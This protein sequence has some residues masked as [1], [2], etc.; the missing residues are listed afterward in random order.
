[1]K[2]L[3][4]ILFIVLLIACDSSD[5]E[6]E[7]NEPEV[8][9]PSNLLYPNSQYTFVTGTTGTTGTP[10]ITNGGDPNLRFSITAPSNPNLSIDSI[11]GVI[12]VSSSLSLGNYNIDV[13]VR[14][15]AGVTSFENI[16]KI[17]IVAA[18]TAP[19]SLSWTVDSLVVPKTQ[20]R[21]STA[22]SINTGGSPITS[23][24]LINSPAGFS[25]SNS[26][27]ITAASTLSKGVYMLSVR[28]TNSVG[29]TDFNNVFR[30]RVRTVTYTLDM[31]TFFTDN[32][33]PCHA[34]GGG[35]PNWLNYTNAR[36][37]SA[38]IRNRVIVVG[39][40]P[41]GGMDQTQKDLL[42]QWIDDGLK[43]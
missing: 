2:K 29:S 31:S 20:F 3:Q 24:Q 37:N 43:E 30:V 36:N 28:L 16:V 42:Q 18:P 32:C 23:A 12:S 4:S 21:S 34:P 33:S 19:V 7:P 9:A 40:M 14:N 25:I 26:G 13:A 15:S 35:Q 5:S 39:N 38:S 10:T 11:T 6:S 8:S 17:I 27:V 1:M 41:P 22:A